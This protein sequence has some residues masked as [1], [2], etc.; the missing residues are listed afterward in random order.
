MIAVVVL[1]GFVALLAIFGAVAE[2][3]IARWQVRREERARLGAVVAVMHM[4][5]GGGRSR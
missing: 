5:N 4:F 2:P 3:A 1:M